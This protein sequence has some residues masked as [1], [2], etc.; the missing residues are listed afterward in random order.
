MSNVSLEQRLSG[1]LKEID[2][3]SGSHKEKL[4]LLAKRADNAHEKLNK[5]VNSLQEALDMLRIVIKYQCFDLEATRRENAVL[6]KLL[7]DYN[8]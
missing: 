6:K 3:I 7:E 2:S 4:V 5:N 1:L 8:Q